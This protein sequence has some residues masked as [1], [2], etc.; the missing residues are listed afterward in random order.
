MKPGVKTQ[1]S[2][3]SLLRCEC[4]EEFFFQ[5]EAFEKVINQLEEVYHVKIDYP[6]QY[7]TSR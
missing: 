2:G 1:K 7:K 6:D 3:L 5:D 4:K